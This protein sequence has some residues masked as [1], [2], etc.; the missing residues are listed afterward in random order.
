MKSQIGDV[1]WWND[2]SSADLSGPVVVQEI[3]GDV[4]W[5][6]RNDGDGGL[7]EAYESELSFHSAGF[8]WDEHSSMELWNKL[9]LV[10]D[11]DDELDCLGRLA[12]KAG[13]YVVPAYRSNAKWCKGGAV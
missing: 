13:I 5:C 7:V 4:Y 10:A 1:R 8:D 6:E 9:C 12:M 3:K 2:P 11:N